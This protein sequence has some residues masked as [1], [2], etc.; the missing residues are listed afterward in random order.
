MPRGC[1]CLISCLLALEGE[2]PCPEAGSG[3][4]QFNAPAL[5]RKAGWEGTAGRDLGLQ[6]GQG[7][8]PSGAT[9]E[10]PHPWA[11]RGPQ[12]SWPL[13]PSYLLP[14]PPLPSGHILG[15][16][17]QC[18]TSIHC[19]PPG[20]PQ[21]QPAR[22]QLRMGTAAQGGDSLL[23]SWP[24]AVSGPPLNSER[25]EL[26]GAGSQGTVRI[27]DPFQS[28]SLQFRKFLRNGEAGRSFL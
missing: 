13:M 4:L 24:G 17:W 18:S 14:T 5:G 21:T 3:G 10:G 16:G 2:G 6:V 28:W 1:S 19:A 7:P 25:E 12:A 27:Q 26:S 23:H 8:R 11:L 20:Q 9:W 22:P 15:K